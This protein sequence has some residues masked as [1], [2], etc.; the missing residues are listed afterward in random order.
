[1]KLVA[2]RHRGHYDVIVMAPDWEFLDV[3]AVEHISYAEISSCSTLVESYAYST[4]TS[5]TMAPIHQ[6]TT[7]YWYGDFPIIYL[8]QSSNRL[9]FIM[10]MPIPIRRRGFSE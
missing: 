6:M 3:Q 1:M 5:N 4:Y 10:R 8:R 7:C 2:T 9:R